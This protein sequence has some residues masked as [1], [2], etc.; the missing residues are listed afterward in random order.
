MPYGQRVLLG[1]LLL[2]RLLGLEL[3]GRLLVGAGDGDLDALLGIVARRAEAGLAGVH[4]HGLGRGQ[5]V[6]VSGNGDRV[7]NGVVEVVK[8]DLHL[9]DIA[10]EAL[11]LLDL[12]VHA[13]DLLVAEFGLGAFLVLNQ[14]AVAAVAEEEAH[15]VGIERERIEEG[16]PLCAPRT[17][18]A[19]RLGPVVDGAPHQFGELGN[20]VFDAVDRAAELDVVVGAVYGALL[21]VPL[22][23][24]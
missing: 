2:A 13:L 24:P 12:P 19:L 8:G 22:L 16:K 3:L 15:V 6:L 17:H 1:L 7:C 5:L 14:G 11:D 23:W 9:V 20:A 18:I 21:A 4:G 10:Q